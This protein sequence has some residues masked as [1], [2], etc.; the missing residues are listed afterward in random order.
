QLKDAFMVGDP[1]RILRLSA[2]IGHYIGDAHVPLHTTENYNG[3]KTGQEGIH[4]FWESRL[5]ELF[6]DDY[7]YFVDKANYIDQPQLF[8]WD[9]I[10]TSHLAMDSV[11]KEERKLA[12]EFGEKKYS[13]E[14][15]G[16]QT[17]KDRKSTRLNSSHVKISYAVFCL[18][19]KNKTQ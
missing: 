5:V 10:T 11:L 16:R 8:I 18:K 14:T 13:F 19:K 9:V 12:R 6:S 2:D 4:A 7:N 15:K 17:I 3:Q 1:D